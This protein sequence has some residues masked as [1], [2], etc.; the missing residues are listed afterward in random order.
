MSVPPET[1]G[2]GLLDCMISPKGGW[3][4]DGG[5]AAVPPE[6]GPNSVGA[7]TAEL[8]PPAMLERAAAPSSARNRA[9]APHSSPAFVP[10][11]V[12][13][14]V[15]RMTPPMAGREMRPQVRP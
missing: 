2:G 11:P 13:R 9:E 4:G 6:V 1:G 5:A 3:K 15:V 8:H 14:L 12:P 10:S 7:P